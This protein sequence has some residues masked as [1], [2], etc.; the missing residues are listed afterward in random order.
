MRYT[1]LMKIDPKIKCT[2]KEIFLLVDRFQVQKADNDLAGRIADSVQTAYYESH[3]YCMV[4]I[5]GEK[6]VRKSFSN[7]FEA[8]G[9]DFEEPSVNLFTFNNPFGAC[10]TCEGLA[11]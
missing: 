4:E 1:G 7:R 9:I 11:L 3:G 2:G 5:A 10:K 6:P 8:D